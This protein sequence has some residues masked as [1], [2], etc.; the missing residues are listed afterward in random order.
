MTAMG[1]A[2]H[3]ALIGHVTG[4]YQADP[5]VR[6]VA[7]FGSVSTGTWHELS[8]VDLDVVVADG[9]V[10]DPAAEARALFGYRAAVVIVGEDSADVVLDSLE[11]ASIRWHPLSVTS[12]N[13]AAAVRVADGR[14]T[15]REIAAAGEANRAVPD[16]RRLLDTLLREAVGAW[17]AQRRGRHWDAIVAVERARHALTALRGRRDD[18]WLD[19]AEPLRA[20]AAVVA[21]AEMSF[22]LGPVRRGLLARLGLSGQG[23]VRI[24]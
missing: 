2:A 12:P 14:L 24:S 7:V 9:V 6:A 3:Q 19:P 18:L 21:E 16:E 4:F 17:K 15:A 20:L 13:I 5:R 1:S 11:E 22:D 8:D 10:I 23:S